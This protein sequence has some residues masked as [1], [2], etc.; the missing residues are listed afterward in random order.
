MK[1]ED[2]PTIS[3]YD[4]L[5]WTAPEDY[6][7]NDPIWVYREDNWWPG[8]VLGTAS[9]AVLIDYQIDDAGSKRTDTVTG[10]YLMRRDPIK[11]QPSQ[12]PA[13]PD[14]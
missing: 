2:R 4:R 11:Q 14:L 1:L 8:D 6:E 3:P 12:A 10:R 7:L 5:A 13:W 9:I